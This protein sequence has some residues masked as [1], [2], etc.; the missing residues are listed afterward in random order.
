M[1]SAQTQITVTIALLFWG[2]FSLLVFL[3]DESPI[4][5][6]SD[7]VFLLTKFGVLVSLGLCEIARRFAKAKGYIYK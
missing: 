2:L 5:P 4:T 7:R 3:S 1:K 6:T